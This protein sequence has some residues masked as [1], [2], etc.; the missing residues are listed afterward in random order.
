MGKNSLAN[1]AQTSL[2]KQ[3][4]LREPGDKFTAEITKKGDELLKLST[5]DGKNKQSAIRY[6]S[7]NTIHTTK[8]IKSK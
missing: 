2:A 4:G 7:T 3:L 5:D 1:I 8:T 6:K